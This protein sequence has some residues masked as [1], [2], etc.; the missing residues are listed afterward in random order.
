VRFIV[1]ALVALAGLLPSAAQAAAPAP[2]NTVVR[3]DVI[4]EVNPLGWRVAAVAI[5]YSKV[6]NLGNAEIANA[7][8]AVEATVGTTT[9]ARTVVDVYTSDAPELDTRGPKGTPGRY[10]I[11]ELDQ[12]DRNAGALV[13]AQ[14]RNEPIPLTGAYAI[15]QTQNVTD[16][17]GRVRLQA[18][19]YALTNQGQIDPVVDDFISARY[20]DSANSTINFRLLQPQARPAD[21]R[22]GFP[23][24][25]FLHGGGERGANNLTQITAN[26]GA[27]AFATP[28]RQ[29]ENPA[30]VLAAQV[31]VGQA[32]TTPTQQRALIELIDTLTAANPI[33][34]DRIYVTGMSLGGIGTF[35]VLQNNPD[36][37]AA[38]LPIAAAGDAT[39]MPLIK[40]VPIWAT[41]SVDDA[42]VSY[43]NGTLALMNALDAAGTLVTRSQ[44]AGNLPD[45]QA[46]ANALQQWAQA[47]ANDSHALLTA[48]T[49]GT[50]PVSAHWSWVPTYLNDVMLDWLFE[51][52]RQDRAPASALQQLVA[53]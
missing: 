32:W 6:I 43:T 30:Y 17:R 4:T 49:A 1:L 21:H 47:E 9:A 25:V 2:P 14:G 13:Y 38:A 22:D 45:R 28:E 51:Q 16:D 24:V 23:L 11:I 12:N 15:R 48:Y 46:E 31:P 36:K 42:T 39:R 3:T 26:Q 41:H 44:W 35:D 29:A 10:L 37:F 8:F 52:D 20:T 18:S 5:E 34:L 33:D 53:R 19:P 7:A 40:D 27:Y 50:T